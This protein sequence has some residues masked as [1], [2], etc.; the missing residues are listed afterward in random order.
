MLMSRGRYDEA[1]PLLH[2]AL[3]SYRA[4]L[5]IPGQVNA[6]MVYADVLIRQG[7]YPQARA[8]IEESMPLARRIGGAG[9]LAPALGLPATL[10]EAQ[11][12]GGS[13]RP[14]G[15]QTPDVLLGAPSLIHLAPPPA[16]T[17]RP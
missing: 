14:T 11:G 4:E 5:G 3:E 15:T 6:G 16:P 10:R 8:L 7:R 13:V 17:A 2:E 12:S 1:E 9:V